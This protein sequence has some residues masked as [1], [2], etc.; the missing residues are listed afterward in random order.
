MTTVT[1]S[2]GTTYT[3]SSGITDNNDIVLNGGTEI[4]ASGGFDLGATISGGGTLIISGN[5]TLDLASASSILSGTTVSSGGILELIGVS[6][7][8]PQGNN[9]NLIA[10]A[11]IE[12]GA[13]SIFQVSGFQIGG[14]EAV[15]L[16]TS[17]ALNIQAGGIATGIAIRGG[18]ETVFS[19][20]TD[21]GAT[22]SNGGQLVISSGGTAIGATI[23]NGGFEFVASAASIA[24][25]RSMPAG[26]SPSSDPTQVR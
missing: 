18:V 22:V 12:I 16:Q 2:S 8:P 4:V 15:V 13:A 5:G 11:I 17:G 7:S 23:S 24:V 26:V 10:G 21:S 1:V 25:L 14:Q 6:G 9:P 3:I 20:G 19:G